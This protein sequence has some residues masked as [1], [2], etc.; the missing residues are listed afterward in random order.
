MGNCASDD[1]LPETQSAMLRNTPLC[2]QHHH[3][4]RKMRHIVA[5]V[6]GHMQKR[7]SRNCLQNTSSHNSSCTLSKAPSPHRAL[8]VSRFLTRMSLQGNWWPPHRG[9]FSTK[10]CRFDVCFGFCAFVAGFDESDSS[11]M[12]DKHACTV[13]TPE[14][15]TP[16]LRSADLEPF[17]RTNS[18]PTQVFRF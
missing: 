11:F 16:S 5:L 9:A 6:V 4:P 12:T 8:P 17:C 14:D 15:G 10:P 7:I 18:A 2:Y 3:L 1:K 13:S